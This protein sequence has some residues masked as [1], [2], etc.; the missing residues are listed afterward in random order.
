MERIVQ[1][2][3]ADTL[4]E[5]ALHSRLERMRLLVWKLTRQQASKVRMMFRVRPWTTAVLAFVPGPVWSQPVEPPSEAL[6]AVLVTG[7]R[8]PRLEFDRLQ[9]TVVVTGDA[10]ES[11]GATNVVDVLSDIPAF[12]PPPSSAAGLQSS[13]FAVAQSYADSFSLGSQRTLTLV[14]GRRF[15]SSN[16]ASIFGPVNLGQ[17]VDL[18][19]IPTKLIDSLEVV[20]VG[21]A[22]VYGSDAIAGTVNLILRRDFEGFDLDVLMGRSERGDGDNQRFRVLA[23]TN[24]AQDRGNVTIN[25]EYLHSDGLVYM[26]RP[27]TARG[28]FYAPP[29]DPGSRY[30]NELIESRRIP[31]I[32]TG[33]LPMTA[34]LIAHFAG[35]KD[36][37]GNVM[38]FG[39]NGALV[40]YAFGTA[41]GSTRECL[42]R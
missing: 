11:R 36:S 6:E 13:S 8:I 23:G 12:G 9:P 19:A 34:D 17:Q 30:A 38:Q 15:V 26:D 1:R 4:T 35:I 33:G 37:S 14:N 24:F 21:G 22:P 10:L 41:T 7:S 28:L 32:N 16:T 31:V 40:P 42:W 3:L 27:R 29:L 39:P 5:L 20:A 25:A 18:N 2:V